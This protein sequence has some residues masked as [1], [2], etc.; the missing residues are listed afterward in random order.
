MADICWCQ[1][2]LAEVFVLPKFM[3]TGC[4]RSI[5]TSRGEVRRENDTV[6]AQGRESPHDIFPAVP[7]M[8]GGQ[9]RKKGVWFHFPPAHLSAVSC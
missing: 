1:I 5:C 3:H 2:S 8:L 4:D 9:H 6:K 7:S